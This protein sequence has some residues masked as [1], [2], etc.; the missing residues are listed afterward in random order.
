MDI[1]TPK[2]RLIRYFNLSS[3]RS[4]LTVDEFH[5]LLHL[6]EALV[7]DIDELIKLQR[8]DKQ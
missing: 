3:R 5:E 2:E 8:E 4:K 7:D 6:E 1:M